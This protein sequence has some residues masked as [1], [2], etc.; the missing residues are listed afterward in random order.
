[1]LSKMNSNRSL[2]STVTRK[3]LRNHHFHPKTRKKAEQTK[4]QLFSW[5]LQRIEVTGKTAT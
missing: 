1:M 4:N 3:K 5:I 2:V